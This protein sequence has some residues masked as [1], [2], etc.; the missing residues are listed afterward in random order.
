MFPNLKYHKHNE[1]IRPYGFYLPG[2]YGFWNCLG[3]WAYYFELF[4]N[5]EKTNATANT[6]TKGVH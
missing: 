4:V 1:R 6:G 3:G 5:Y 2:R